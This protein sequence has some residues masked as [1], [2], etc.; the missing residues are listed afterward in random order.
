[1]QQVW[2]VCRSVAVFGDCGV[3]GECHG[4]WRGVATVASVDSVANV[5]DCGEVFQS[6]VVCGVCHGVWRNVAE[7]GGC[8]VFVGVCRS[9]AES[10]DCGGVWRVWR[11]VASMANVSKCFGV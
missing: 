4:V 11:S 2:R 3:S 9:V 8:V 7:C 5:P 10:C 1:M 6:V